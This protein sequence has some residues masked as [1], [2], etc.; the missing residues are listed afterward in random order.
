M[1]HETMPKAD[2]AGFLVVIGL[3]GGG[4]WACWNGHS[5]LVFLA[6]SLVIFP[7]CFVAL[8]FLVWIVVEAI[9]SLLS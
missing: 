5:D 6:L 4:I 3:L 7:L 2:A 9:R 8:L 1:R